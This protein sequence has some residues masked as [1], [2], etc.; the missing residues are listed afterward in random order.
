[1]PT[2]CNKAMYAG[3]WVLGSRC[4]DLGS[5]LLRPLRNLQIYLSAANFTPIPVSSTGQALT[6]PH[7]GGRDFQ[8]PIRRYARVSLRGNDGWDVVSRHLR[9]SHS[10]PA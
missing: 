7:Q 2:R 10:E 3:F 1:M 8:A 6:F 9:R 4:W 5:R